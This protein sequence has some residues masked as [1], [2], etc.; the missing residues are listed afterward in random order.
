MARTDLAADLIDTAAMLRGAGRDSVF[1]LPAGPPPGIAAWDRVFAYATP[2][3]RWRGGGVPVVLAGR[4]CDL[5]QPERLAWPGAAE[6]T[7]VRLRRLDTLHRDVGLLVLGDAASAASVLAGAAATLARARPAVLLD[8]RGA[9]VTLEDLPTGYVVSRAGGLRCATF[10]RRPMTP[11]RWR[12]APVVLAFDDDLACRGLHP[13]EPDSGAG[14]RWTGAES[15]VVVYV[16]R[17]FWPRW[18][19]TLEAVD[20]GGRGMFPIGIDQAVLLPRKGADGTAAYG[21]FMLDTRLDP[22]LEI[23][24]LTGRPVADQVRFPRKIGARIRRAVLW[25]D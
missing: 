6:D 4:D 1:C 18:T 5:E 20:W 13:T 7:S 11:A 17:P 10:G 9:S 21:P 15:E 12:P 19:M 3:L 14:G 24:L 8:T 16:S 22:V 23:R 2:G 25:P